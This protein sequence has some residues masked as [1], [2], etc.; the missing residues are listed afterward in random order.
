[1]TPHTPS[2]FNPDRLEA[3]RQQ[4]G[5]SKTMFA[6]KLGISRVHYHTWLLGNGHPN[7]ET[8]EK[9]AEACGV[10][11]AYFFTERVKQNGTQAAAR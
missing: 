1:M 11:C 4:L 3:L 6:K 10:D 7:V 9:I 5:L 2:K 8:L